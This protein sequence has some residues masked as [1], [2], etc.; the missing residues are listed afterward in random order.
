MPT[1]SP[2]R[3][4]WIDHWNPEDD[5]FWARTGATIA[6]RNLWFSIL[7]EH[8]GFSI[9]TMWSVLVLFMGPDYGIDAAGKFLLVSVPTLVGSILRLPYAF[10]V[11]RFGG[12]NWTI[13][14]AALLL[15][16]SVLAA[17]VMHPGTS[18]ATFLVVAAVGGL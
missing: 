4:H 6:N 2:L 15:V 8:I 12:R 3:A 7:S 1:R 11:T 5:G 18:F 16:P 13:V 9:W 17:I 14:S 10:A